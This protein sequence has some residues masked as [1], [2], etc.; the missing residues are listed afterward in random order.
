[1]RPTHVRRLAVQTVLAAAVIV[2]AA[3]CDSTDSDT[4]AD[5]AAWCRQLDVAVTASAELDTLGRDDPGVDAAFE[6][7]QDEMS[8]LADL[9]APPDISADWET[10]SGPPPTDDTGAFDLGDEFADAGD[11]IGAWALDNCDLSSG[12][13]AALDRQAD[14]SAT[15]DPTDS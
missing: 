15:T 14:S 1:M 12:A 2:A 3:A 11:R 7:V 6:A 10:V 13:R 5:T 9:P 8:A 4:G